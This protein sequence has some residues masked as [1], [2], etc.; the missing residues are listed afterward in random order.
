MTMPYPAPLLAEKM[1]RDAL[2]DMLKMLKRYGRVLPLES[3]GHV[4]WYR[5][6]D[7]EAIIGTPNV[8]DSP[9]QTQPN[10][11]TRGGEHPR[12]MSEQAIGIYCRQFTFAKKGGER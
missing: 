11:R 7:W 1:D 2:D 6:K 4:P 10:K 8:D 3:G 5:R 9:P 12:D